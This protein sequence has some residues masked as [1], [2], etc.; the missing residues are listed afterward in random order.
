M[1]IKFYI[2]LNIIYLYFNY[3]IKY[4]KLYCLLYHNI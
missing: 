2:L 4:N 3:I 1:K